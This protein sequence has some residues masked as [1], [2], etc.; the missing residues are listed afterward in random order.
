MVVNIA[1]HCGY[2]QSNFQWLEEMHTKYAPRGLAILAFP[3][4][5]F[6]QQVCVAR[7]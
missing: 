2:T 5:E 7:G 6:G 3:S 4:N 1:A